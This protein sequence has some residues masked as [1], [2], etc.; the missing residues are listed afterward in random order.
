MME[1]V[2]KQYYVNMLNH[3]I[4][5]SEEGINKCWYLMMKKNKA[6]LYSLYTE[7]KRNLYRFCLLLMLY[8]DTKKVNKIA[9]KLLPN[10]FRYNIKERKDL[11][12]LENKE[13]AGN[14]LIAFF[15]NSPALKKELNDFIGNIGDGIF[16]ITDED[17]ELLEK[18]IQTF[19]D[20][21]LDPDKLV[22]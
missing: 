22:S 4:C 20:F 3:F 14:E 18:L 12:Y 8:K 9:L 13:E 10:E 17:K 5:N 7:E 11:L 21:S 1:N 19:E 15:F 2:S 16:D 6:G